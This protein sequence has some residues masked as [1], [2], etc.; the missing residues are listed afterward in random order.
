MLINIIVPV[1]LSKVGDVVKNDFVKKYVYNAKIAS[2][3]CCS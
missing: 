3:S 2:Y 1:D